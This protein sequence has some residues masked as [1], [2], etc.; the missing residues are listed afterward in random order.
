MVRDEVGRRLQLT[1]ADAEAYYN[2]HKADY[3][4]P[5][6]V[7]LSEILIATPAPEG[8]SPDDAEV[9]AAKAK[10]DDVAAQLKAGAAFDELAKKLSNGPTA[11][12]GGDLGEFKR[13]GLAKE[14]ED[15]TFSLPVGGVTAPI[16]TRQGFVL[17]KV[18]GHTA[19]GVQPEADVENEV[20]QAVYMEKMQPALRA[21]LTQLREEAYI[22][23]KP[24]F[25]DTGAS[26]KQTKPIFTA[27]A[28]P[29]VKKKTVVEKQ[30]FDRHGHVVTTAAVA[31]APAAATPAVVTA[32]TKPATAKVIPGKHGKPAKIKREK[33]RFGQAPRETLPDTPGSGAAIPTEVGSAQGNAGV[34]AEALPDQTAASPLPDNADPLGPKAGPKVKSRFA[35]RPPEKKKPK[36]KKVL[37]APAPPTQTETAA[38]KTQAAPL[39]LNGDT[40][41]KK[42][43]KTKHHGPKERIT[44]KPAAAVPAGAT[45]PNTA[46]PAAQPPAATPQS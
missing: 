22:D 26:P 8:K 14:L 16:R 5:E 3:A 32:S 46:P 38:E 20:E 25:I 37:P 6:S 28:A 23:I 13:G 44:S 15:Q 39:G 17:L 24:G 30:R 18:T 12:Q 40:S 7:K 21:Y 19:A 27:Y 43:A 31:A 33:V 29:T 34:M 4:V 41:K 11:S 36:V 1:H 45:S 42:K 9:A 35:A 10:A 2:A